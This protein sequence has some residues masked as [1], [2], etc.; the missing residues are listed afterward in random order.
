MNIKEKILNCTLH[1][2]KFKLIIP[3][4]IVQY[5]S[6]YIG[7][8][9]NLA[10]ARSREA[11]Q[12]IGVN[13]YYF[14]GNIGLVI[15]TAISII[16]S[17]LIIVFS[18][19]RLVLRRLKKIL[20]FTKKLGNGDL[21]DEI[22]F[23]GNDDISRLGKCLNKATSNIKMLISDITEIS[24][25]INT[26]SYELLSS[27]KDSYSSINVINSTSSVLSMDA[28]NLIDTTKKANSSIEE[29]L[30]TTGLLLT[31]VKNGLASSTEMEIRAIE[32]N[33]KVSNSLE[34]ANITYSEKQE[35][36]LKA[37]EASNVVE[38][39]KTISDT[40]KDI[41]SQ[42]NLLALNAAIEAS[43]AGEHGKGFSVVAR[44]VKVL[45]EQSTEAISNVDILVAQVQEVFDNLSIILQD[46][47]AYI[48]NNVKADY[49]LLLETGVQYQKDA[50]LINSISTEVTSSAGIMDVSIDKISKVIDQVAEMSKETADATDEINGSL[51]EIKSVMNEANDYMEYQ[52][53][54]VNRLDKSVEKFTL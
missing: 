19:D 38:E 52:V 53:N 11:L 20:D 22:N 3:I 5:F 45:A 36:I 30:K 50:K 13:A 9:V 26:S 8:G 54:L 39:I 10:M 28:F 24:K 44:E 46:I 35:K 47:L 48:D 4:V 2:I 37:I 27:T 41:S 31:Q 51:S 43:R 21:S 6:S 40:I 49:E 33:Q 23:E 7:Q 17:V 12:N 18:Y 32:M 42:T 16:I 29:I 25:M 1:S 14:D 15:S 34:K